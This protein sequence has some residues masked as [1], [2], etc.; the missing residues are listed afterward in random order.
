MREDSKI[1]TNTPRSATRTS[2]DD[3]TVMHQSLLC[4]A[5]EHAV[6]LHALKDGT[7]ERDARRPRRLPGWLLIY[8]PSAA[9]ASATSCS[10]LL[11]PLPASF[12]RLAG[13]GRLWTRPPCA[14]TRCTNPRLEDSKPDKLGDAQF[15][16]AVAVKQ[17]HMANKEPFS[18]REQRVARFRRPPP[19]SITSS[20]RCSRSRP[21][22]LEK[23]DNTAAACERARLRR[24]PQVADADGADAI[25]LARPTCV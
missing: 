22:D 12:G 24:T 1:N 5:R 25:P 6:C 23:Q 2:C 17:Q 18:S 19:L 14:R 8:P 16:A 10:S 3:K 7:R 21:P 9:V 15:R 13:D 11:Y 20:P 4:S